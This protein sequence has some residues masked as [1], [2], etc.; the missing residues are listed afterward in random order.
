[1][2]LLSKVDV[3][4]VKAENTLSLYKPGT[5]RMAKCKEKKKLD[6]CTNCNIVDMVLFYDNTE[7]KF[8]VKESDVYYRFVHRVCS[9]F[10][11]IMFFEPM[12]HFFIR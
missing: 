2:N 5:L 6:L 8:N 4:L 3:N 10:P 1:M 12:L 11:V 9:P 7:N